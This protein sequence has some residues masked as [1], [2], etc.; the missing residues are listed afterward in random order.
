MISDPASLPNEVPFTGEQVVLA[1]V[2]AVT[3]MVDDF[4]LKIPSAMEAASFLR[5]ARF[6]HLDAT[7][8]KRGITV[9][10]ENV[11]T[12]QKLSITLPFVQT[13]VTRVDLAK[14]I[15]SP[16]GDTLGFVLASLASLPRGSSK[17][18][19]HR[20]DLI[21][22]NDQKSETVVRILALDGRLLVRAS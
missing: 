17:A 20:F 14:A 1:F 18:A 11:Q 13:E 5:E 19:G 10:W 2:R 7:G 16:F 6:S 9:E 8:T 15:T 22:K 21:V 12:S 4:K 3:C